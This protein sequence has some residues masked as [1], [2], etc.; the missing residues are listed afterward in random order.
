MNQPT[1][2]AEL[3]QQLIAAR[4]ALAPTEKAAADARIVAKLLSWLLDHQVRV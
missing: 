3:R 2:K 4:R 1:S